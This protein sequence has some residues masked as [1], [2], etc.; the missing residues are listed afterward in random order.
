MSDNGELQPEVLA[1]SEEHAIVFENF[2][3]EETASSIDLEVQNETW[4]LNSLDSSVSNSSDSEEKLSI[5]NSKQSSLPPTTCKQIEHGIILKQL[6][7]KGI[8]SQL[9]T[10]QAK[11]KSKEA[12]CLTVS[13]WIGIGTRNGLVLVFDVTQNLKWFLDTLDVLGTKYSSESPDGWGNA[14]SAMAF[15]S[16]H[17]RLLVGNACGHIL[18]YDMKDGKLVRTLN[19]VHPPE[20]AILHLQFTDLP[21]LALLCDSGGNVF[22][23]GFK[24]TLGVRG[25]DTRCLFSGSRGEVCA[26]EPLR[27][28][29]QD[30]GAVF[31][32]LP[33]WESVVVVAMATL[34]KILIVQIRPSTKVIYSQLLGGDGLSPPCLGWHFVAVHSQQ[35]GRSIEPVLAYARHAELHFVQLSIDEERNRVRY[36]PLLRFQ[37]DFN[38]RGLQWLDPRM[39]ALL[40]SEQQVH[41]VDIKT[42]ESIDVVDVSGVNLVKSTPFFRGLATGGNV[43]EALAL[44]GTDAC[45]NSM[46]SCAGQLL[47]LCSTSLRSIGLRHWDER[48]DLLLSQSRPEEAIHLGLRMLNGKAKA[49]HGLKGTPNQRKRQLKDKEIDILNDYVERVL[50]PLVMQEPTM[51]TSG[52]NLK[53]VIELCIDVCIKLQQEALLF[54]QIYPRIANSEAARENF[55]QLLEPHFLNDRLPS[56]PPSIMQQFVAHYEDNGWLDTLE[57]CIIHVDVSC[58]DLHQILTLSHNQG[59]FLAYLYV[60]TRALNDYVSP[61]EDLL[62]QLQG[63]V[64]LGPPY[65]EQDLKLGHVILVYISCCLAGRTYPVGEID[66]ESRVKVKHQVLTSLT[67]LHSKRASDDEPPYPYLR[68]LLE[69]NT[70]ELLNALSLAFEES[71]FVGEMGARRQQ[72]VIDILVEIMINSSQF[73]PDQICSLFTFIARQISRSPRP[74]SIYLDPSLFQQ[75]VDLVCSLSSKETHQVQ[76][77]FEERQQALLQLLQI[78]GQPSLGTEDEEQLLKQA[79]SAKFYRVCEHIYEQRQDWEKV[80]ECYINDTSRHGDILYF[81]RN[82]FSESS[83]VSDVCKIEQAVLK[84]IQLLVKLNATSLAVFLA[85]NKPTLIDV[86]VTALI[87]FPRERYRFLEAILDLATQDDVAT[88]TAVLIDDDDYCIEQYA[89]LMAELEPQRLA[90]YV[91]LVDVIYLSRLLDI[92]RKFSILE[93]EAAVLERQGE[94]TAAYDLLLGRLQGCIQQLF[95]KPESWQDFETASQSIIDFCQ[96]QASSLTEQEREKIWLTLLDELLLPQRSLKENPDASSTIISGLREVTQKVVTSIQGQI[97]LSKVLPRLIEDPETTGGTLGDLRQLIMGLL[98]NYTYETTLLRISTRLLQGDV[99]SLLSQ[100][101]RQSRKGVVLRASRCGSCNRPLQNG[102]NSSITAFQCRHAFHSGCLLEEIKDCIVCQPIPTSAPPEDF[103]ALNPE[104][105]PVLQLTSTQLDSVAKARKGLSSAY[106]LT[107]LFE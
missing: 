5:S 89:E 26:I 65:S 102:R 99:H 97:S 88:S 35:R 105:L 16:E 14:I 94:I 31:D 51:V 107:N 54:D 4:Q 57:S 44:V 24:R 9:M 98:D 69:F 60:H 68:A 38:L 52:R 58:L 21:T 8:S 23:L 28:V 81:L 85:V 36:H 47:L 61:L 56:V 78:K 25:V 63:A 93:A 55:L 106:P 41:V 86:A 103:T 48:L 75:L 95:V 73:S 10:A 79:E 92:C 42:Q 59:L 29:G 46:A 27:S 80:F 104:Q 39:L 101:Y 96:R 74:D 7:L 87:P 11:L 3:L 91:Q 67:C 1:V 45:Y 37:L 84:H 72:R 19:D 15:N 49:M 20:A 50:V 13:T 53:S 83:V 12:T 43:S 6:V 100:R 22:E 71:E 30:L 64:K 32:F 34:S 90:S 40:D 82:V 2:S 18:E 66:Q 33:K 77:R 17:S 76:S 62:K 70:Q